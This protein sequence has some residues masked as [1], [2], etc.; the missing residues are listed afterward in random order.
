MARKSYVCESCGVRVADNEIEEGG[1]FF[2]GEHCYCAICVAR[3]MQKV[4]TAQRG[5]KAK[6]VGIV[7]QK[8]ITAGVASAPAWLLYTVIAEAAAAL[9]LLLVLLL[10]GEVATPGIDPVAREEQ[11][12]KRLIL[13]ADS[14][15]SEPQGA[16]KALDILEQA[17]NFAVGTAWSHVVKLREKKARELFEE[18]AKGAFLGIEKD[19]KI[20]AA[21]EEYDIALAVLDR[22]PE[23]Y[24]KT[25][26]YTVEIAALR[27]KAEFYR[28][29]ANAYAQL[30]ANIVPLTRIRKYDEAVELLRAF[31][32]KYAST[33]VAG[34]VTQRTS[35]I[36]EQRDH[37][38][39]QERMEEEQKTAMAARLE[40][41]KRQ[42]E[43]EEKK[44][45]LEEEQK[46][47]AQEEARKAAEEERKREQEASKDEPS[48]PDETKPEP[49]AQDEGGK[50]EE[51]KLSF[52]H[53]VKEFPFDTPRP[54]FQPLERG[55][56]GDLLFV[57]FPHKGKIAGFGVKELEKSIAVDTNADGKLDKQLPK[58]G[59]AA[60]L[61][62][63]YEE[64]REVEFAVEI[65]P[66]GGRLSYRRY[67]WVAGRINGV[68]VAIIDENSNGVF[69]EA[70]KDAIAIG[71]VSGAAVLGRIV[72]IKDKYYEIRVAEDG[73][74]LQ[75][76]P[77]SLETGKLFLT[78]NFKAKGRLS[79]AVVIGNTTSG[80]HLVSFELSQ[81]RK[82]VEVPAGKYFIYAGYVIAP[83]KSVIRIHGGP[84]VKDFFVKP[85]EVT[86]PKWGAPG[87]MKFEYILN[88]EGTITVS[89]RDIKLYGA[90]GERY[91]DW[92][93]KE[94]LPRVQIQ[95]P[96]GKIIMDKA[97]QH[98]SDYADFYTFEEYVP[99]NKKLKVRIIGDP[100]FLGPCAS[101]WK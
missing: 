92:G 94:F 86:E 27:S 8:G 25:K 65:R 19:Y 40:E 16:L 64:G 53:R 66:E 21:R 51:I 99:V 47:H 76:R 29:A 80:K 68:N 75:A 59:G 41:A 1:A 83:G 24:R 20:Q 48:K 31:P 87:V 100:R 61:K 43:A 36:I 58:T 46:R 96:T 9:I 69:G 81:M 15:L 26:Y 28:E 52:G 60:V 37:L 2:D 18:D 11:Q 44:R 91:L 49:A 6:T 39:E 5:G 12:I 63:T 74:Q 73:S 101:E 67:G 32:S 17:N 84:D 13:N 85:G 97:F 38:R 57:P 71:R 82:A 35:E 54:Y 90:L 42:K 23:A 33:P 62:V 93:P 70:G 79:Y 55:A 98:S 72:Q 14:M 95:D 34:K 22:F 30:L 7:F 45:I 88:K 50:W 3:L 4:R 10:P 56:M 89:D 78:K 77:A